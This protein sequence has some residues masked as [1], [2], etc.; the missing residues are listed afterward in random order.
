M[1]GG[2]CN[3]SFLA[4]SDM[5]RYYI[6]FLDSTASDLLLNFAVKARRPALFF[7]F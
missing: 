4:T 3:S 2:N 1:G 5:G 7:F 6:A